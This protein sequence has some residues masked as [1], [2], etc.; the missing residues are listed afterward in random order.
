[1]STLKLAVAQM[2]ISDGDYAA[3][4][5]RIEGI[6]EQAGPE[7]DLIV[8]PETATSGFSRR[9]EV[10]RIAEPLDGPTVRRLS[11]RAAVHDCLLVLGLPER[12]GDSL[13]NSAVV[14]GRAGVIMAYRKTHLWGAE[15]RIFAAGDRFRAV[16]RGAYTLGALVCYDVEFPEP[17]R[18]LATMG[19]DLITLC[20]G[21][22]DPYGEVHRRAIVAR[23]QEN[24]LFVAMANR[25][26]AGR[27]ENFAGGSMVVGPD[28]VVLAEMAGGEGVLSVSIDL[29]EVAAC[30]RSYSY[31]EDRRV[32]LQGGIVSTVGGLFEYEIAAQHAR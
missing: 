20:N 12:D 29:D 19:C 5:A 1:M 16:D 3:N 32:G 9:D 2:A 13:H 25:V 14:I 11:A 15:K 8:L 4:I 26:G 23:A 17:A 21:N 18:V 31:L 10:A 22:M 6:V 28:G 24:Q 7:H 30:R 27:D